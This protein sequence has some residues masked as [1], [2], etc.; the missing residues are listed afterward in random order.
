VQ[1]IAYV[2]ERII[3]AAVCVDHVGLYELSANPTSPPNTPT[4]GEELLEFEDLTVVV[5]SITE[6]NSSVIVGYT[7]GVISRVLSFGIDATSPLADLLDQ[8]VIAELPRGETL[9]QI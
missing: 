8:I 4:N 3:V 7:Q 1:A 6:L 2:K 9:N 5:N